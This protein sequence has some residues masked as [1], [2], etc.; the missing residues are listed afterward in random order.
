MPVFGH[1]AVRNQSSEEFDFLWVECEAS[2]VFRRAARVHA[3]PNG[4]SPLSLG[5]NATAPG[6]LPTEWPNLFRRIRRVEEE[7]KILV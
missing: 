5:G 2:K 1:T 6:A 7:R 3:V 4:I